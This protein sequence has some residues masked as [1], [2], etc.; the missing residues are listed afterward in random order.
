MLPINYGIFYIVQ[1]SI[2]PERKLISPNG[3]MASAPMVKEAQ[4]WHMGSAPARTPNCGEFA[5]DWPLLNLT[6][7][8]RSPSSKPDDLNFQADII[9]Q[10][11]N[12]QS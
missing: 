10:P 7:T 9:K 3:P 2:H 8:A 5:L 11:W 6:K 12:N 1:S 4:K